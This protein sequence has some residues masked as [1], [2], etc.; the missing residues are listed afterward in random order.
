VTPG[1]VSQS[2][3][4]PGDYPRNQRSKSIPFTG[5]DLF[6]EK[7]DQYP[8]RPEEAMSEIEQHLSVSV[9]TEIDRV[10]GD[11][12]GEVI[13]AEE[14]F[15]MWPDDIVHA[16]AIVAEEAG[17]ATRASLQVYYQGERTDNLRCE[18]VQTAAVAIRAIID[19]DRKKQ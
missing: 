16:V 15:P 7:A 17:E 9:R 8:K 10:I 4:G 18:L 6:L 13:R 5:P 2:S 14:K 3:S 19:I 12:C 11:V 1:P